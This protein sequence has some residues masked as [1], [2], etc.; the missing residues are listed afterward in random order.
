MERQEIIKFLSSPKSYSSSVKKVKHIDTRYLSDV[1]LTGKFAYK[2]KKPVNYGYLDFTSL[3]KRKYYCYQELKLNRRFSPEMYLDVLPLTEKNGQLKLGGNGQA[4][5]YVLKM[6]EIPQQYLMNLLLAKNKINKKILVKL[7]QIIAKF[8]AQAK[9]SKKISQFGSLQTIKQNWQENFNQAKP[10]ISR[11]IS[12][13]DFFFLKNS[14]ESFIKNNQQVFQQR[15][16]DKKIKDCHG[17]LHKGNIFVTPQKIYIF[18]CIDFNERFRYQDVL[19]EIAF[20]AMEMDFVGRQDLSDFFVDHY[21]KFS[22]DQASKRLFLFYKCYRAYIRAKVWCFSLD[23]KDLSTKQKEIN[24]RKAQKYFKLAKKYVEEMEEPILILGAGLPGIGR[25]IRLKI[26]AQKTKAMIIDSDVL[27]QQIKKSNYDKKSKLLVYQ[28]MIR[29]AEKYLEHG[30]NVIL[31]AT[32]SKEKYRQLAKNLVK[33]LKTRYCFIEFY[34]SDEIAKLRFQERAKEKNPISQANWQVYLKIKKEW[35]AVK[36]E[37]NYFKI[38]T[39][40]SPEQSVKKI[41]GEINA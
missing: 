4:V 37:D 20:F 14:I 17:D 11:A 13:R 26:L 35:Q 7:A 39:A 1:F 18:D 41:I 27:R 36:K 21:F 29:L 22:K 16:K 10:F 40:Q 12:S 33:K 30:K 15:I 19:N 23:R 6:K 8:H 24:R 32:F 25:S 28:K 34:C 31:D 9:S 38:N 2:I 5:E 3:A